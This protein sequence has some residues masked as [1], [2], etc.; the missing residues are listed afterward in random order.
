MNIRY[1]ESENEINS[2]YN[3]QL[4]S[5]MV[6]HNPRKIRIYIAGHNGN[7]NLFN[8][9]TNQLKNNRRYCIHNKNKTIMNIVTF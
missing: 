8:I 5:K 9:N 4:Y 2:I 6:I 7:I 1:L 3:D